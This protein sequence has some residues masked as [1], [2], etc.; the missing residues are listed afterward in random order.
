MLSALRYPLGKGE[1]VSSILTGSTILKGLIGSCRQFVAE[2]YGN[3]THQ[4]WEK[5][6]T[7]FRTR[8]PR[9]PELS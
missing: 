9:A 4:T 2:R 3:T 6:W 5:P 8:S 1:V 7:L